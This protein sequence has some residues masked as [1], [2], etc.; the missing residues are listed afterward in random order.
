MTIN[1]FI[2]KVIFKEMYKIICKYGFHYLGFTL[3]AT[4]IE[5][6]GAL[7][8]TANPFIK[9]NRAEDRFKLAMKYFPRPYNK[10]KRLP[11]RIYELFRCGMCHIMAPACGIELTHRKE[12]AFNGYSH[13]KK[14]NKGNIVLVVEDLYE[15]LCDAIRAIR[16]LDS[17]KRRNLDADFLNVPQDN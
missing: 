5:F 12:A 2:D 4:A 8:D 9:T 1:E 10:D 3:I 15:D 13:L 7:L 14:D 16:K 17:G 6:S 11:K